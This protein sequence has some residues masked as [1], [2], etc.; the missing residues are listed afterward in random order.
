MKC[1]KCHYQRKSGESTPDWQC[2]ACGI[3]YRKFM[4]IDDGSVIVAIPVKPRKKGIARASGAYL[5]VIFLVFGAVALAFGRFMVKNFTGPG[6]LYAMVL[7]SM[8][9]GTSLAG[10]IQMITDMP[11]QEALNEFSELPSKQKA[12]VVMA[13]LSMI[14]LVLFGAVQLGSEI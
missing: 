10:L 5:F 6:V 3:A 1:P 8:L 13:I 2:P 12:A 14:G 4:P 7:W 11:A 9:F